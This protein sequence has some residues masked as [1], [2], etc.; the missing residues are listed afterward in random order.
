MTNALKKR[1]RDLLLETVVAVVLVSA[2]V[3]YVLQRPTDAPPPPWGLISLIANTLVVFGF[4][5]T[6]FRGSWRNYVFWVAVAA[7][8]LAHILT[9]LFLIRSHVLPTGVYALVINPVELLIFGKILKRIPT[10]QA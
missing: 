2:Y 1:T 10:G 7:L 3:A 5:L 8:F 9:L 4:L 6:W